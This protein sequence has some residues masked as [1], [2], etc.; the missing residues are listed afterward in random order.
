MPTPTDPLPMNDARRVALVTDT[1]APAVN[2]VVRSVQTAK[3]AL[4]AKGADVHVFAPGTRAVAREIGDSHVSFFPAI[5]TNIYPRLHVSVLPLRPRHL[6]GFDV[7]HVHTPGPLGFAAMLCAR[8]LGIPAVYTYHTRFDDL[9]NY[10]APFES[11]ERIVAGAAHRLE[12]A[13][14]RTASAVVAPTAAIA[15]ELRAA[16]GIR[17]EV[18]PTGVDLDTFR[19]AARL[20]NP[21]PVFLHL[22]RLSREKN[23][24]AVLRAFPHVLAQEPRARLRVAGAGPDEGRSR[25]LAAQLGIAAHVDFLG[26]V[27]EADLPAAYQSADVYVSASLFETQGL[28]VLEAMACGLPAAVARCDVFADVIQGGAALAFD[29]SSPED[30]ARGMLDA[31]AQRAQLARAGLGLAQQGSTDAA[32][33][34]LEALYDRLAAKRVPVLV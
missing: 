25:K 23:L 6:R 29:A 18:I 31:Y 30:A 15:E 22:G 32:V 13:L 21:G 5:E 4:T 27:P 3:Q 34:A 24:E 7:V 33:R 20:E 12:R 28:T 11:A 9:V 14:I 2:G 17:P 1:Y 8:R 16:H 26:F 19:P 10:L